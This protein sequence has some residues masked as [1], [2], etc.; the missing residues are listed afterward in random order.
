MKTYSFSRRLIVTVL[1]VETL[2]ALCTTGIA[3]LYERHQHMRTFDVMLRGR[4][5]SLLGAVQDSEDAADDVMLAPKLL[6]LE[7]GDLYEVREPSGHVLGRS[8]EWNPEIERHF[9]EGRHGYNFRFLGRGYRGI[10]LHGVRQ[11]DADDGSAGIS[12]PVIIDY[13]APLTPVW[14]AMGDAAKFLLLSNSLVLFLTGITIYFLLRR[15][16]APLEMLAA[17]AA[18]VAPPLWKFAGA[19]RGGTGG[20]GAC[21]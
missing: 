6:D 14:R 12:R 21:A 15:G 10:V 20:A 11:V 1:L 3:L 19:R 18:A 7:S 8:P 2:L 9:R 17:E 5:D 4:A 16:M 13:A